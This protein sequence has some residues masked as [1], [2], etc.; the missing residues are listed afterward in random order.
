MSIICQFSDIFVIYP[1][2]LRTLSIFAYN[3]FIV[4]SFTNGERNNKIALF[5]GQRVPMVL[6]I[7]I[8]RSV[9]GE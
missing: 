8:L 2:S 3:L 7:A 6:C 1:E 9:R 5:S 4:C